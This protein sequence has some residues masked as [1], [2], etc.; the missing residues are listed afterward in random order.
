MQ[1][2]IQQLEMFA[3]RLKEI[4]EFLNIDKMKNELKRLEAKMSN[5]DFWKNQEE[6]KKISGE[7][8]EAKKKIDKWE[9]IEKDIKDT[10]SVAKADL[11]DKEVNL[12][13]EIEKR[14]AEIEKELEGLE[15]HLLFTGKHDKNNAIVSFHAGTG[16]VDAQDFAEM[17]LRMICRYA[18]RKGFGV[19]IL[20][21]NRGGEAGI[22]SAMISVDGL[23]AYGYLKSEHG[24]HRLV[25]ISPFDAEKMRHT[26]F[27]L[28]EV[29]PELADVDVKIEPKDIKIDT[30]LASGAGGQYVQKTES[31]VRITHLPTGI[32]VSCQS[33]RSQAQNKESAMKI[34]R[35][36]L[37]QLEEEEMRSEKKKIKG[38]YKKAAWSN[39]IRSYVLHPYKLVKDHRTEYEETDPDAVLDGK[40]ERFVEEY[41]KNIKNKI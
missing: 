30:F 1:D 5:S 10:L 7:H 33:E 2:L 21:E 24:V 23:Y 29:L 15:I 14:I 16:G 25:R 35:A 37:Y 22:K 32:A 17:L 11:K 3:R 13:K 38:E 36:K 40:I 41:L 18:E 6:A 20:D 8:A 39:Q 27:A 31:A 12:R 28:I 26:S 19:K 34:L 9:Q 4:G